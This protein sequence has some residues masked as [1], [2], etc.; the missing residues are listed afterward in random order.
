MA[1][2]KRSVL[3]DADGSGA[4]VKF[5]RDLIWRGDCLRAHPAR[6]RSPDRVI[7]PGWLLDL[8]VTTDEIVNLSFRL[9]ALIPVPFLNSAD[10]FFSIA[11]S[12]SK[13]IVR[14]FAP[15]RFHF[16]LQ[17]VPFAFENVVVHW[18]APLFRIRQFNEREANDVP[19]RL[20]FFQRE[21]GRSALVR[22]AL[23]AGGRRLGTHP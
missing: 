7:R 22:L 21:G 11:L 19:Q 12:P 8:R 18:G 2:A 10:Q 3:A 15:L 5:P 20:V 14:Q 6:K 17:L 16:A 13:V 23:L 1:L 9:I 4:R